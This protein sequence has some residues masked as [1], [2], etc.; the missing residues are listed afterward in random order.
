MRRRLRDAIAAN[1]HGIPVVES[2]RTP[3]SHPSGAPADGTGP[4]AQCLIGYGIGMERQVDAVYPDGWGYGVGY[5]GPR[6]GAGLGLGLANPTSTT[7]ASSPLDLYDAASR[8]P[9][10]H[11][12][13]ETSLTGLIRRCRQ[14][15]DP[16]RRGRHLPEVS[17]LVVAGS[18][19]PRPAAAPCRPAARPDRPAVRPEFRRLPG[20][21]TGRRSVTEKLQA[22]GRHA[23]GD[24]AGFPGRQLLTRKCRPAAATAR[25][26]LATTSWLK[27]N[28]VSQRGALPSLVRSTWTLEDVAH[29]DTEAVTPAGS[30]SESGHRSGRARMRTAAH[31]ANPD[32]CW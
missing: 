11:A 31:W 15:A 30:N 2:P 16:R 19:G 13:A 27:T 3:D 22:S 21:N 32:T 24:G 18:T 26:T 20:S 4:G 10:W 7:E 28:T 14:P 17:A 25:D 29:A 23:E 6:L 1:L 8:K 9:M 12:S 5:W